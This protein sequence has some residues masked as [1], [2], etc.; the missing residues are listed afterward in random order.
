[1]SGIPLR[2]AALAAVAARLAEQVPT[3]VVERARRAPVDTDVESLPRLILLGGAIEADET[4][5]PGRT[6]YQIG[7]VVQ[8]YAA[9]A[10]DLA[11]EQA[12]SLLH[13]DIVVA[14]AGWTPDAPGLG[15]ISER[16]AEIGLFAVEDSATPAGSFEARFALL[17]IAPTGGPFSS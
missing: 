11:A 2:E 1:M 10:D 13:A 8:G 17:A 16:G 4:A 6:H 5:E 7:F 3:A 9:G 12:L 15:D 14:L